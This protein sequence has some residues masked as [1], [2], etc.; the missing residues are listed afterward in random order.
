[1]KWN[2]EMLS[3]RLLGSSHEKMHEVLFT[4]AATWEERTAAVVVRRDK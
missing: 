4:V 3:L 1:V 2:K